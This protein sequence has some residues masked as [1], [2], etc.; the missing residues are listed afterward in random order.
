MVKE[1]VGRIKSDRAI[2][3]EL[4]RINTHE[5]VKIIEDEVNLNKGG[6]G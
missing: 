3:L 1:V 5:W 2:K 6:K 4:E